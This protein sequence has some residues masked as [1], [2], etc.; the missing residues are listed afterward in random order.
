MSEPDATTQRS[1]AQSVADV[2][3]RRRE[4]VA[5]RWAELPL[6]RTVFTVTR[7]EAVEAGQ[8]VVDALAVVASSGRPGDLEASGFDPVRVQI[9]R[10][11]ASRSRAGVSVGQV[12]AEVAALK[13]A[14]VDLLKA[15]LEQEPAEIRHEAVLFASELL[16]TLRLVTLETML[17]DGQEIIVRQRQQLLE[18]ATPVIKLWEGIVAVP[19]IGTLD[20]ARSQVVMESLLEAIVAQQAKVVILDITGVSTVDTLVAQHLMKTV[21]SARLMGAE[22]IVSGIRP[23]IAQT[24][25][26]L[27]IDL[28]SVI[29]RSSLADAL[30]M[31]LHRIGL[32]VHSAP[33][34]PPVA[35]PAAL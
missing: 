14:V 5:Q 29:T 17:D 13:D 12:A 10:M 19:L 15:E 16:A 21:A 8:S 18:G 27:G 26:Q 6:F 7:D 1:A 4:Q 35:G 31:A 25:V 34:S 20:S 33:D 24:I 2:L 11:S 32:R 3:L 28:G 22:C 9:G 23:A 30:A